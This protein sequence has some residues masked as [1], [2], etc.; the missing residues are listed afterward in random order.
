M[1]KIIFFT[2][3]PLL[4][5]SLVTFSKANSDEFIIKVETNPNNPTDVLFMGSS[6]SNEDF[7]VDW[8]DGNGLVTI[9]HKQLNQVQ[10]TLAPGHSGIIKI[11]GNLSEFRAPTSIVDVIQWGNMPFT[12]LN[13]IFQQCHKIA[14]FSASDKPNLTN[15]IS[16]DY[17][18]AGASIFK[19]DLNEW[20]VSNVQSMRATFYNTKKFEG[21]IKSWDVSSVT[22]MKNMF[23]NSA[24]SKANYDELLFEWS[25]L[26]LQDNVRLDVS[27]YYCS[28]VTGKNKIIEDHQWVIND[29]GQCANNEFIFVVDGSNNIV[30]FSAYTDAFFEVDW[31]GNGVWERF[32]KNTGLEIISHTYDSKPDT[33]RIRGRMNKFLAPN[34]ITDVVQWGDV[35]FSSLAKMFQNCNKL[36]NFTANDAPNLSNVISLE[37]TF[38]GCKFFEGNKNLAKWDVSNITSMRSTFANTKNFNGSGVKNWDVSSVKNMKFLFYNSHDFNVDISNWDV[39]SAKYMSG[40]F[41]GTPFSVENYDKIL[42]SWSQLELQDNV[43]LST[44]TS[45]CKS[46][47]ERE[48]IID[49]YNW[50][51]E[52]NDQKCDNPFDSSHSSPNGVIVDEID[53]FS[54]N[55]EGDLDWEL[56]DFS[57]NLINSG[58]S[59]INQGE[60]IEWWK[61]QL[62]TN[63]ACILKLIDEKGNITTLKFVL[64]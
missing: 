35:K 7:Y 59:S 20:N 46:E 55:F 62:T 23:I 54:G 42:E 34:N 36:K 26:D 64:E 8:G 30:N 37:Y 5:I 11:S 4:L 45:Y 25:K 38:A 29:L 32:S 15:V 17:A 27:Q 6:N 56:Y 16:M 3:I 12:T 60:M 58:F 22:N 50:T 28:S 53:L 52:D 24:I 63:K 9:K 48:K 19:Q 43:T 51:I 39:S 40:M 13:R 31:E 33:I 41:Q 44:S 10:K 57:G 2:V 47:D 14:G 49:T 1:K 18:F 61:F 21:N